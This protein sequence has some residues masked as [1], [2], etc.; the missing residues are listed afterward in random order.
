MLQYDTTIAGVVRFLGW[1]G[2]L[3][4]VGWLVWQSLRATSAADALSGRFPML[5]R[6]ER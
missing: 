3:A 2:M 6:K 1:C 4:V 5:N